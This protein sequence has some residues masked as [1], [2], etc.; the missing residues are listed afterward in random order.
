MEDRAE[1]VAAFE[2]DFVRDGVATA[3]RITGTPRATMGPSG[4][5]IF[6]LDTQEL[7][8]SDRWH[9]VK[10]T[11]EMVGARIAKRL[12]RLG[13]ATLG[14]LASMD[15]RSFLRLGGIGVGSLIELR[16]AVDGL[17]GDR[18]TLDPANRTVAVHPDTGADRA[19]RKPAHRRQDTANV[20]LLAAL[21][22]VVE[23]H[24]LGCA[25]PQVI[26]A[27]SLALG[28]ATILRL[29]SLL[30]PRTR[31]TLWNI[32][33]LADGLP[34]ADVQDMVDKV[35]QLRGKKCVTPTDIKVDPPDTFWR[36]HRV[37]GVHALDDRW[38]DGWDCSDWARFCHGAGEDDEPAAQ[39][40]SEAAYNRATAVFAGQS[41]L[42]NSLTDEP[43]PLDLSRWSRDDVVRALGLVRSTVGYPWEV[44]IAEIASIALRAHHPLD[45]SRRFVRYVD[46]C[47]RGLVPVDPMIQSVLDAFQPSTTN[48]LGARVRMLDDYDGMGEAFDSDNPDGDDSLD[49]YEGRASGAPAGGDGGPQP[50]DQ[51]K[52]LLPGGKWVLGKAEIVHSPTELETELLPALFS[53]APTLV[54]LSGNAG[55]GKTAFIETV[56]E[57]AG[58]RQKPVPNECEANLDGRPYLI[59]LDGSEDTYDKS[60]SQLL[61]DALGEFR[62]NEELEPGRGTLIAV[63][64]GRLL[65]FLEAEKDEYGALWDLAYRRFADG[66]D[67]SG[68][69]YVLVDLNDRTVVGP[70]LST[71]LFGQV[72]AKLLDWEGWSAC[73]GCVA[74]AACPVTFN[75]ESLRRPDAQQRLWEVFGLIDLDDRL[76]VTARHVVTRLASIISGGLRCPDIRRTAAAE[77]PF[78]ERAYFYA[79]AFLG[80]ADESSLEEAA[81]NEIAAAYDP[82]ETAEPVRDRLLGSSIASGTL[83]DAAPEVPDGPNSDFPA[84]E[85]QAMTLAGR[86]VDAAPSGSQV[87]YREA[88]IALISR[89]LRRRYFLANDDDSVVPV[90]SFKDYLDVVERGDREQLAA[91]ITKSL[92]ATLG[93]RRVVGGGLIVPREYS[94]GLAGSGFALHVPPG[95]FE[96]ALG[97]GLGT[98][99]RPSQFTRSWPRSLLLL[100]QDQGATFAT[101]SIPLLMLEILDRAD[102][103]FRPTSRTER[104]YMVRVAT[105]YRR[106]AEHKWNETL[107][108]VLYE[109]GRIRAAVALTTDSLDF[110]VP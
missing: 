104:N 97:T 28:P 58:Q 38:P 46:R 12:P 102:R 72:L 44:R 67:T 110:W 68:S 35:H 80:R 105:F 55:D 82:A 3:E 107:D 30:P 9:S 74:Q 64:K 4:A 61:H 19:T 32:A 101:L 63:N 57:A 52:N 56:L 106:L 8:R 90:R 70:S 54:I 86:T 47:E 14:D 1:A 76:H 93:I 37:T 94:R 81:L 40:Y 10:I 39:R 77:R 49:D 51:I 100:A 91:R 25:C 65:S 29:A 27:K 66:E 85:R 98:E 83:Q 103:G 45:E 17:L 41:W 6:D 87:E 42:W 95:A 18:S 92:N 20:R 22:A 96:V 43:E 26:T 89:L 53:R 5:A 13:V 99:F 84:I 16:V 78:Q 21:D 88:H 62:G 108:Y 36:E 59:V 50:L 7:L 33:L 73:G 75:L 11:K 109:R 15:E 31:P 60:N 48:D 69:R 34:D 24:G 79:G 71:S 23:R 2:R